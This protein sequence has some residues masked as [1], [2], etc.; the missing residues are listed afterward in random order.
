MEAS[1]RIGVLTSGGDCPGLN[2]AIRATAKTAFTMGYEVIGI[3]DGWEG[4]LYDKTEVLDDIKTSGIIDRGGTILGASRTSPLHV[5]NG[6]QRVLD[7]ARDLGL[8]ALVVL[9]G[10]GTLSSANKLCEMGLPVVS[11]PKTID[12]DVEGTDYT[13]GFQTAVQIATDALDRLRSTAESHHRVM[14]LEVMGHHTGWIATYTGLGSG[15]DAILIPEIPMDEGRIDSLCQMLKKRNGIG[16]KFSIVV[17]AEGTILEGAT[18]MSRLDTERGEEPPRL[19]GAGQ[20]LAELVEGQTGLKARVSSLGYIQRGG[21]PVAYDRSLAT[22]F[23]AKA[24]DLVKRRRY[25]QMTA[26]RGNRISGVP[27]AQVAGRT[28]TVDMV[29]YR[30]AETFFG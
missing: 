27:L 9:G 29:V 4:L 12:N 10:E 7:R 21:T 6:P 13:I 20:V 11:I 5:D 19:G 26:L 15:A 14:I 25:G 8:E 24:M 28:K 23:G 30:I 18:I 17:V 1:K 3:R 2:A 22:A 16:M